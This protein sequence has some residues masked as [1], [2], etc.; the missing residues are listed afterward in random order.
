[1]VFWLV[2][3]IVIWKWRALQGS[4]DNTNSLSWDAELGVFSLEKRGPSVQTWA[5]GGKTNLCAASIR[6]ITAEFQ[7][8]FLMQ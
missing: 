3:K 5:Q 2:E 4:G 1:M 7:S 6:V 8:Y